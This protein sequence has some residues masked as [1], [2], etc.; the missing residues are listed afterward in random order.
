M[1][2]NG[3]KVGDKVKIPTSKKGYAHKGEGNYDPEFS[4]VVKKYW[5]EDKIFYIIRDMMMGILF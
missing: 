5:R 3:V 2:K 1:L 4:T